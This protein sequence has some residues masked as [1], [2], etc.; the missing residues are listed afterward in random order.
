MRG[1]LEGVSQADKVKLHEIVLTS[2][3]HDIGSLGEYPDIGSK[4]IFKSA[5]NAAEHAIVPEIVPQ[6]RLRRLISSYAWIIAKYR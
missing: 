4:P 2:L 1:A 6:Q 5:A 3:G